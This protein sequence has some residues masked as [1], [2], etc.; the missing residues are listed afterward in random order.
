MRLYVSFFFIFLQERETITDSPLYFEQESLLQ[1]VASKQEEI[2]S[3]K[4]V[5]NRLEQEKGHSL[6]ELKQTQVMSSDQLEKLF[7]L[8][9]KQDILEIENTQTLKN[10]LESENRNID[11]EKQCKLLQEENEQLKT[12]NKEFEDVLQDIKVQ[13]TDERENLTASNEDYKNQLKI[14]REQND[15]LNTEIM[16]LKENEYEIENRYMQ[17]EKDHSQV[18]QLLKSDHEKNQVIK[19]DQIKRLEDQLKER[20]EE[21][22]KSLLDK[23]HLEEKLSKF[24]QLD[25][26]GIILQLQIDLKQMKSLVKSTQDENKD[27]NEELKNTKMIKMLKNQIEDLEGEKNSLVRQKKNLELDLL[28]V[29]DNLDEVSEAKTKLEHKYMETAKENVALAT[30]IKENEDELEDIMKK[31]KTSVAAVSSQQVI[32]QNQSCAIIDLEKEKMQLTE[33]V[34]ELT[35]NID[36]LEDENINGNK[37]K[38]FEIKI[39]DLEYRL[40][41]E[42]ASRQRSETIIDRLKNKLQNSE[43]DLENMKKGSIGKDDLNRKLERQIKDLKE[44]FINLQIQEMDMS[45]KKTMLEKKV[46]INE[47][48]IEMLKSQLELANQRIEGL[49]SNLISDSDSD[50]SILPCSEES[51]DDLDI[52]LINHRKKMAEQKEEENRIR[53]DMKD[54][55]ES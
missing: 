3:L 50:Y 38:T 6:M 13:Q 5:C 15:T 39:K 28:E 55:N 10:L 24:D 4:M 43:S 9:A 47:A 41:L 29:Q 14:I 2:E 34:N 32:L 42:E 17:A 36:N 21:M 53:K 40:E 7:N 33:T 46:E 30:T 48:E 52:F 11:L 19:D 51:Q 27:H 20:Q 16:T 22:Q 25:Y 26:E 49:H 54:E 23:K 44:D 8:E 31:Y 18:L 37:Y 45:E 12:N 35:K 1:L